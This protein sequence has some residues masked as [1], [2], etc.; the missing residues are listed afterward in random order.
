MSETTQE[1]LNAVVKTLPNMTEASSKQV[2]ADWEKNPGKM[3]TDNNNTNFLKTLSTFVLQMIR[4]Q[5]FYNPLEENNVVSTGSA[6]HGNIQRMYIGDIPTVDADFQKPWQ[7]GAGSDMWKKRRILPTQ[8][9]A[10]SNISYNNKISVPGSGFYTSAFSRYENIVEFNAAITRAMMYTYSRWRFA[11]FMDV[12]GRQTALDGLKPGQ[13]I[14]VQIADPLAPTPT[15]ATKFAQQ[16]LTFK[17]AAK[18][19]GKNFNEQGFNY[20]VSDENIKVLVPLGY[21]SALQFALTN[22]YNPD[23]IYEVVNSLIEVP[24]IGVPTYYKDDSKAERLY[25]V[26]DENGTITGLNTKAGGTGEAVSLESAYVDTDSTIYAIAID[27]RRIN[28][29]TAISDDG[30]PTELTTDWTIYNIEGDYRNFYTRILGNPSEGA[31]AR[32][33]GDSSYL[34]TKFTLNNV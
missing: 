9:F 27:N 30:R 3:F 7:D 34:F 13:D 15:E 32:L 31:G 12:I 14:G 22:I 19:N 29:L 8:M 24:F 18:L 17:R 23:I 6:A 25:P 21:K 1:M 5:D 16:L 11:L 2:L 20:S 26:Y 33:F 10:Y 4:V 28:Y